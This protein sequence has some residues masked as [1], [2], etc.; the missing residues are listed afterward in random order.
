MNKAGLK[1]HEIY[2]KLT[3]FTEQELGAIADFIDFMRHKKQL[4]DKKT[5]LSEANRQVQQQIEKRE[6]VENQLQQYRQRLKG[7]VEALTAELTTAKEQVAQQVSEHQQKVNQF[8]QQ[9]EDKKVEL[10][11]TGEQLKGQVEHLT[12]E[13]TIAKEQLEQQ[14]ADKNAE[15][16]EVGEQLQQR[17]DELTAANE[18]LKQQ[19]T[20]REQSEAAGEIRADHAI[21]R[22]CH[23]SG[24]TFGQTHPGA[25]RLA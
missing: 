6:N 7:Q 12:A 10:A 2:N 22:S 20:E 21:R 4:E 18:Q 9:L 23:L 13:L 25:A 19:V 14:V 17:T 15:L 24:R 5:E 11:E 16:S 8:T 1:K 3:E